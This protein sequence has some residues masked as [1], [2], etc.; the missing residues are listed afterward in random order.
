MENSTFSSSQNLL[1]FNY[2]KLN[3]DA[4]SIKYIESIYGNYTIFKFVNR[5][6]LVSSYTLNHYC[7]ILSESN[8]FFN[9]RKGVL[10]NLTYM[11]EL[12]KRDDGT[13]AIMQDGSE[14]RLSRRKGKALLE[15][16]RA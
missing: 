16:L 6:Q 8:S 13:Y 10:I 2:G 7:S 15:M 4:S 5:K 14:F 11:K 1:T 3:V 9:I 12:D